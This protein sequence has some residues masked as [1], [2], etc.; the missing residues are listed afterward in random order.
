MILKK[1]PELSVVY[2]EMGCDF[3]VYNFLEY[4]GNKLQLKILTKRISKTLM[5][6]SFELSRV[7]QLIHFIIILHITSLSMNGM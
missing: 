4:L 5:F 6:F 1:G 2:A 7:K 3:C